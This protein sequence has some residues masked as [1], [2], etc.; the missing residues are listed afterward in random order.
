MESEALRREIAA[1][2]HEV[3]QEVATLRL[4]VSVKF[5]AVEG[6]I[7]HM[8]QLVE[9]QLRRPRG[10]PLWLVLILAIPG[11]LTSLSMLAFVV[12]YVWRG[13]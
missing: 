2:D 3:R 12:G 4:L 1:G 6:E 11:M 9:E 10:A 8:A 5:D 13:G 7:R